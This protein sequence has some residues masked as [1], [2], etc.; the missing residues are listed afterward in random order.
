[1]DRSKIVFVI[2][3]KDEEQTIEQILNDIIH[4]GNIILINDASIDN[5]YKIASKY[6]IKIINNNKNKFKKEKS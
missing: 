5:T 1:M 3:A 2:P 4:I 6:D